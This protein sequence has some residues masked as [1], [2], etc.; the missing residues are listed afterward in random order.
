MGRREI[1]V[2]AAVAALALV[3]RLPNLQLVPHL[4][5]ETVEVLTAFDI[6]FGGARPLTHADPYDG[7][8]WP[9]L[10]A[11]VLRLAGPSVALPRWF[12]VALGVA[13]VVATFGLAWMLAAAAPARRLAAAGVAGALMATSFGH[14]LVGSRVAWSNSTT[15]LWTTLTLLAL[16]R[17]VQRERGPWL[18]AS[19]VLAGL[20]L[21]THPS[22][23]LFL[24]A[25]GLWYL[26]D[27]GRRRTLRTPWPW[28][29]VAAALCAYGPVILYNVSTGFGS[30]TAARASANTA[31]GGLAGWLLGWPALVAQLGRTMVG[32]FGLDG[33]QPGGTLVGLLA[34][35]V[36]GVA[37]VQL[38]RTPGLP[39]GRRLPLV[40]LVVVGLGLPLFNRNWAGFLE[41]RYLADLLPP[42]YAAV[43]VVT[44]EAWGRLGRPRRLALAA[45]VAAL[46]VLPVLQ[47]VALQ[48][49]ALAERYDNRRLLAMV[50]SAGAVARS[51][52][53]VF[54]DNDLRQVAWR[55]GGHPRRAIEYLLTLAGVAFT[56][57][58]VAKMNHFLAAGSDGAFFL[59]GATAAELRERYALQAI[60]ASPRPGE[61]A[62]GL[63]RPVAP[64]GR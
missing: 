33:P 54:V 46:A 55:A 56:R 32:G 53:P 23:S 58:P 49:A 45:L 34:V 30:V 17:A 50:A 59:A 41:T 40:L 64:R 44:A 7:P 42:L 14:V 1:L 21:H 28:L 26:L 10:L 18:V 4:T 48:R 52:A 47:A 25:L 20:A 39:A 37:V 12:T 62:W 24:V 35:V 15:P 36:V 6:A 5:D 38:A 8:L 3:L 29:A 2:L 13:T 9:Y 61:G 60:D 57:A 16:L 63:Y 22:V 11:L 43:G 31:G 27:A 51:G 19:G